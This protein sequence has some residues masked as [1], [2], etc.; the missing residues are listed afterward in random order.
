MAGRSGAAV[1]LTDVPQTSRAK[2]AAGR[3]V[4][5]VLASRLSY[6][7]GPALSPSPSLWRIIATC[8]VSASTE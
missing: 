5:F 4:V 6:G 2:V 7:L 1:S 3:R 8:S